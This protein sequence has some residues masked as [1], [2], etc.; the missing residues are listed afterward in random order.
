MATFL[1]EDRHLQRM[2]PSARRELLKILADDIA[3]ATTAY[4][5]LD[6]NPDGTQSYPLTVEEARL[7]LAGMPEPAQSVMRTF[8]ENYD[9]KRGT[10][11]MKQ[12]LAAT[13]HT[14]WEN[15]GKQI[16]WI[17]LRLRSVSGNPDAWMITWRQRDWNWDESHKT[18][19][20]GKYFI[21]ATA[22]DALREAFEISN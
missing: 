4:A 15:L 11:T 20:R 17:E 14:K 7:L 10:A 9:G 21:S 16:A 3:D 5:G 13:G 22:V 6:W 1:V 2:S 8:A 12:L 18:Y 19:T